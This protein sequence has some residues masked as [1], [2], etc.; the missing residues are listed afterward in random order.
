[1]YVPIEVASSQLPVSPSAAEPP[2]APRV[3]ERVKGAD[4]RSCAK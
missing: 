2:D 1:M 4:Y 3:R